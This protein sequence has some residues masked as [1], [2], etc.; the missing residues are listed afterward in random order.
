MA[1]IIE[2]KWEDLAGREDLQGRTVRI[3][4]LDE[5]G[6]AA[7]DPWLKSLRAWVDCHKPRGRG[8]DDSRSSIYSGTLDDPR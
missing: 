1:N 3:V 2:G 6:K 5:G 4:V 7:E 8:V